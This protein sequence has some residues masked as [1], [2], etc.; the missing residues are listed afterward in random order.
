MALTYDAVQVFAASTKN[1]VYRPQALNCSEQSNQVQTDGS[2]FK[3]YM[4]SVFKIENAKQCIIK[5]EFLFV[6][7]QAES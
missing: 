3:N 4:R 2:T 5:I 7:I 6:T 1:L